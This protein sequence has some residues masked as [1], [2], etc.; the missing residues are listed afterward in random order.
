M[1][2]KRRGA[3]RGLLLGLSG[4]VVAGLL[5]GSLFLPYQRFQ[6]PVT[7]EIPR[8][9]NSWAAGQIL[10]KAGVLAFAWQ[11][12]MARA[13]R[14]TRK[15]Q[16]GEYTFAKALSP[17]QLYDRLAKG[18]S[19][20]VELRIPEGRNIFEIAA[21]VGETKIISEAAFLA[22]AQKPGRIQDLAP[23][24]TSLEGF[25]FPSTYYLAKNTTA[26]QLVDLMVAAFRKNW[27]EV[28]K[29]ADPLATVTLASIVEK[30]TSVPAERPLVA[31]VYQHRLEM[32][33]KLDADP[34]TAYAA[35]LA[36]VWRG[37]IYRSDLER[38]HPYNTYQR[39][40]LPPGPIA[41][42]GLTSLQAAARP[43][44]TDYIFFVAKPDGSGGHNF[45]KTSAA[46]E[47]A[48]REYRNGL[49]QEGNRQEGAKKEATG[50]VAGAREAK[51][52]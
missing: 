21:L 6:A 27:K 43:E 23:G 40:G 5:A 26:A 34:T 32:G 38:E 18:E 31:G 29:V 48:V 7:V 1:A 11:L 28:P 44:K 30:E 9:T 16:A 41:N 25:L 24:A 33:M 3:G 12:P 42:P 22:E 4:V 49:R 19:V 8:G 2:K 47:R 13:L 36:G 50:G 46:H 14:P 10:A 20:R 51:R 37:T 45:S 52:R 17:W 35:R 15:M 39:V